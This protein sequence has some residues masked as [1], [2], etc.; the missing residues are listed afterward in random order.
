MY[1]GNLKLAGKAELF[2]P[3]TEKPMTATID[4]EGRFAFSWTDLYDTGVDCRVKLDTTAFVGAV[5]LPLTSDSGVE[6]VEIYAD[7]VLVGRQD[8][9][10]GKTF[11]G[12]VTVAVGCVADV[13]TVRMKANLKK[14]VFATPEVLGAVCDGAP[15]VWPTP[16]SMV[17]GEGKVKIG[18]TMANQFVPTAWDNSRVK[19]GIFIS[20]EAA[21]SLNETIITDEDWHSASTDSFPDGI[22][23]EMI[24]YQGAEY[25]SYKEYKPNQYAVVLYFADENMLRVVLCN[26]N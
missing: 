25:F 1:I 11:G 21:E 19:S 2:R 3:G 18:Y 10:T 13:I 22:L 5:T 20:R 4:S 9:A 8:A 24:S 26:K 7:G 23:P 15:L 16:K 12:V 6:Y 14:I 17:M